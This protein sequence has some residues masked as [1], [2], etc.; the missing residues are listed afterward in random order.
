M[1][2]NPYCIGSSNHAELD[3]SGLTDIY[4][5]NPYCIGSSNHAI[6]LNLDCAMASEVLILIVLDHL[7]MPLK[8]CSLRTARFVLILIVLDHLIMHS[9]DVV[10]ENLEDLS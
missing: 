9:S 2:L 6:L 7:I 8:L 4:S 10:Q 1:G 3:A 5:L